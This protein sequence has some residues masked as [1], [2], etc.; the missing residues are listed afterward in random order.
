MRF[1]KYALI[2]M[3]CIA[4]PSCTHRAPPPEVICKLLDARLRF[5]EEHREILMELRL[6]LSANRRS[7]TIHPYADMAFQVRSATDTVVVVPRVS[8]RPAPDGA[9]QYQAVVL[10]RNPSVLSV[11]PTDYNAVLP[12][13]V[14]PDRGMHVQLEVRYASEGHYSNFVTVDGVLP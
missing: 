9:P 1:V 14:R 8:L 4:A 6:E 7:V 2:G 5:N 3:V 11:A 10:T 12:S 13:N